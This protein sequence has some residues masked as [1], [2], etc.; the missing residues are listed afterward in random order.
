MSNLKIPWLLKENQSISEIA[1]DLKWTESFMKEMFETNINHI[2]CPYP[3][4]E[5]VAVIDLL[6]IDPFHQYG[7]IISMDI[8]HILLDPD[9]EYEYELRSLNDKGILAATN[10]YSLNRSLVDDE[11]LVK[12]INTFLVIVDNKEDIRKI[13]K[14]I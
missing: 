14:Y 3:I 4:S 9:D 11:Y 5:T 10:V 2:I 13:N 12:R 1:P 7:T 6:K 8:N